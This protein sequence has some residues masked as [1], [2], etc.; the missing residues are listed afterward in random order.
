[1]QTQG[2]LLLKAY[3]IKLRGDSEYTPFGTILPFGGK[4]ETRKIRAAAGD[5]SDQHPGSIEITT[6]NLH[7][8]FQF[9]GESYVL[10]KAR[11]TTVDIITDIL[12][13]QVHVAAES[14]SSHKA[15]FLKKI[16]I[17]QFESMTVAASNSYLLE[18]CSDITYYTRTIKLADFE[19]L[20]TQWTPRDS[21]LDPAQSEHKAKVKAKSE[22]SAASSSSNSGFSPLHRASDVPPRWSF[23][24]SSASSSEVSTREREFL[25]GKVCKFHLAVPRA[26]VL[27]S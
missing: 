1:M 23:D 9:E 14:S 19:E 26:F 11:V 25:G 6:E 7:A 22:P 13:V 3:K 18:S 8:Q 16:F 17:D 24:A 20:C 21:H 4:K 15:L 10:L 5:S 27:L 2:L 12:T